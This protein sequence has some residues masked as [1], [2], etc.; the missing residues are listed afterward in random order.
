[1]YT[2]SVRSPSHSAI[3][4]CKTRK[5][6]RRPTAAERAMQEESRIKN[7]MSV[8]KTTSAMRFSL[9]DHYP[10]AWKI[11]LSATQKGRRDKAAT[12]EY[13][14]RWECAHGDIVHHATCQ[15]ASV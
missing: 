4:Q 9:G 5:T 1:M 10:T 2:L 6:Q 11:S 15:S 13:F 12:S 8:I 7:T 3:R 14:Q